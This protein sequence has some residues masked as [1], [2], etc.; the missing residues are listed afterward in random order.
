[1]VVDINILVGS[2]WENVII[3]NHNDYPRA[4]EGGRDGKSGLRH[5]HCS[6]SE[7]SPRLHVLGM[8]FGLLAPE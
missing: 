2:Q 6:H 4:P 3:N 5:A 7:V 1:M 8:Q